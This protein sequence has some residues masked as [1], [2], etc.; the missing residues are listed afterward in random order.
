MEVTSWT[1]LFRDFSFCIC[2]RPELQTNTTTADD[3]GAML[4]SKAGEGTGASVATTASGLAETMRCEHT[5]MAGN[6][7]DGQ[8]HHD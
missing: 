2:Y 1:F 7:D 8:G 6:N 3:E 4:R 5:I